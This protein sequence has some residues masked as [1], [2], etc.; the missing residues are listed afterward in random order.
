MKKGIIY[1]IICTMLCGCASTEIAGVNAGTEIKE[2]SNKKME[3]G[4]K[5]N[6]GAAPDINPGEKEILEK[7]SGYYIGDSSKKEVYLT[8]DEGY[9]NGYT[10][11]ILDVLKKHNVPA[12]FF[13]TGPYLENETELI[14]R[15]TDEGHIVGNHTVNHPSMPS[16]KDET[17]LENELLDLERSYYSITGKP[18][19]YMRPP[20]GEH[21]ERTLAVAEALG[22]KSIFWSIAYMD[23]DLKQQ[24]GTQYVMDSILDNLHSGAI[25]LMHAVSPD[26]AK[27]LESVICEIRNRGYE[28]KSLDSLPQR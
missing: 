13:V 1:I 28:F 6:P 20:K 27:A 4:L 14:R 23:W 17:E 21:S 7:Y 2:L 11:Q 19:K 8:F 22:Y 5:K 16:V 3:W 18:M 10:S 25:I 26:N 24:K 9:E 15:M 12:C